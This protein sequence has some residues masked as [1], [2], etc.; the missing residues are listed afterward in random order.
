M[1]ESRRVEVTEAVGA[2]KGERW[3]GWG[4]TMSPGGAR[5]RRSGLGWGLLAA[6]VVATSASAELVAG[7]SFN[8]FDETIVRHDATVG[9][10]FLDL[11]SLISIVEGYD[12]TSMN[13][14]DGWKPGDAL[15]LRGPT[16]E[17][18]AIVLGASFDLPV[19]DTSRR[20]EL[21]FA[22]RRS[23]TGFDR[24]RVEKWSG[25]KW[26]LVEEVSIDTKWSTES[27]PIPGI[28]PA[29]DLL[30]RLEPVGASGASGTWRID[31]LRLD[32]SVV[33]SPAASA[34]LIGGG[35]AT[36]A[37]RRRG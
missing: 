37:G 34:V 25:S 23:A 8:G 22:S 21:S 32:A 31:N 6:S 1:S 19:P 17:D 4:N 2:R 12:G 10:G 30:L 11:G 36:R 18:G 35:I 3:L 9:E 15:G 33:P 28:D 7:W 14:P 20:I 26:E 24:L 16:P 29:D 5:T 27:I 13:A